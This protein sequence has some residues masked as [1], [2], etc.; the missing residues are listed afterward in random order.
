[1]WELSWGKKFIK[2]HKKL[3]SNIRRSVDKAIIHIASSTDPASLGVYKQCMNSL[4]YKIGRKHR[5]I[6]SIRYDERVVYLVRVGDH[7][8]VYNKD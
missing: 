8:A 4:A 7:K 6:Y 5:V 1:M 2:Q 3:D